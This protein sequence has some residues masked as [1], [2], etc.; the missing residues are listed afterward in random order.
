[1]VCHPVMIGTQTDDISWYILASLDSRF[2][3]MLRNVE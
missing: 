3:P 2:D 1:M